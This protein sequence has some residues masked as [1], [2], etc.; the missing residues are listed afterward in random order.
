M[1][2]KFLS[3]IICAVFFFSLASPAEASYRNEAEAIIAH[4]TDAS[5]AKTAQEWISSLADTA[6]TGAE[7]YVIALARLGYSGFEEYAQALAD[8]LGE[9]TVR[10][11]NAQRCA[12]GFIAA[13]IESKY[14]AHTAENTIGSQG[15]M[16]YIW[17]LYILNSGMES[18]NFS[19]EGL[20][21]KIAS[22]RKSDGGFALSGESSNVDVTAMA[23]AALS[24]YR[25]NEEINEAIESSLAFLSAAQTESGGFINYGV[26]NCESAAQVIVALCSL[27]INPESD[28]RF[29][30]KG[31]TVPDAMRSF[32]LSGG[33]YAH[34]SGGA[35]SE[36]ATVQALHAFTALHLFENGGSLF[37]FEK[38]SGIPEGF[39]DIGENKSE[40]PHKN[41]VDIKTIVCIAVIAACAVGIVITAVIPAKKKEEE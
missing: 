11:T 25:E 38:P 21:E 24:P 9:K 41:D 39:R 12:L 8:Y 27:G 22:L 37:D 17:G 29:I 31:N 30:K 20:A 34:T 5:G 10:G 28:T 32:A 6:G 33:G 18:T 2:K 36:M 35:E 14:I 3:V 26:E 1:M 16:S 15:I 19:P 4:K 23:I 13:G 40:A 7:W